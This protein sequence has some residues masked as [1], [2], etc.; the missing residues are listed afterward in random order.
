MWG[1]LF[2]HVRMET[3]TEFWCLSWTG[4]SPLRLTV[5]GWALAPSREAPRRLKSFLE[6]QAYLFLWLQESSTSMSRARHTRHLP[7]F[8]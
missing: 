2:L 3:Q 1:T 8:P 5:D 7:P 6:L 4:F